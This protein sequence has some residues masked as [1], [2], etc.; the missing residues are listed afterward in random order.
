MVR[1]K[2]RLL[3]SPSAFDGIIKCSASD[4]LARL[5]ARVINKGSRF[6]VDGDK[7]VT[8]SHNDNS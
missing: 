1:P 3:K 2:Y 8:P 6:L 4:R 5:K 7:E